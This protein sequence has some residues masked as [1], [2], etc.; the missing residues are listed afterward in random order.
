MSDYEDEIKNE[1]ESKGGLSYIKLLKEKHLE[2]VLDILDTLN[3]QYDEME[4]E[5]ENE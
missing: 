1:F 2:K 3:E 4:E 5:G